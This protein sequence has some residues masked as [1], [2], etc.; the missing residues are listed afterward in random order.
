MVECV[1][2]GG[3][4]NGALQCMVTVL[5]CSPLFL[6]VDVSHPEVCDFP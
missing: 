4:D 1:A 6:A 2:R 3:G 5:C